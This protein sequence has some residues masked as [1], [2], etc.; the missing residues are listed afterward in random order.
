[1]VVAI[2]I[3]IA[4]V[5]TAFVVLPKKKDRELTAT[6][7]G[8]VLQFDAGMTKNLTVVAMLGKKDITNDTTTTTLFWTVTPSSVGSFSLKAKPEVPFRAAIQAGTGTV[9]CT[10]TYQETPES[11]EISV[12][13][14]KAIS[15]LP[16]YLDA[17]SI[18]P[19]AKTILPDSNW[20]FTATAVSSVGLPISGVDFTWV[21]ATDPGVTCTPNATSGPSIR[22]DAGAVLGNVTL[23]A[24][25]SYAGKTKSGISA[26]KV[27]YL[28]PRSVDYVWY[29]M[30][31]VPIGSWYDA[32]YPIYH[33]EERM[34]DSYPWLF[35]YHSEPDGNLY[36][37]SLMRLNITGRNVSEI[38][39]NTWPEFL[40]IL[41]QSERGGTA[42]IDWYMQYLTRDE[43]DERYSSFA[44]QDDGWIIVLNGT[45]TL[46]KQAAKMVLNLTETGYDTFGSWWSNNQ[47]TVIERYSGFLVDEAESRVD[48][49]NAYESYYQLFT[50]GLDATKEGDKI[51]LRYDLVTWGMEALMLRWLHECFLP[52]EMW[53]EDMRFHMTIMPEWSVIDIDTA[54]TY[55]LYASETMSSMGEADVTP[56]WVFQ[57]LLGDA[58]TSSIA[59]PI[60]A[61]DK[62]AS[63]SYLNRQP[64]STLYNKSMLYD[65]VPTAWNLS[66]NETLTLKWPAGNQ[67]FRY[68]I[69]QGMAVN[70]TE[71][72]AVRY[73]EPM[74]AD[75]DDFLGDVTINNTAR[76]IEFI[77][78]IN[79][80]DWSKTQLNHS[81]LNDEWIRLGVLPYGMPWVEFETM[82]PV[83]ISL[84]HFEVNVADAVPANDDATVTVTAINNYGFTYF[85]YDGN[86]SFTCTDAAA[87]LPANYTFDPIND[88]GVHIFEGVKFQT[89]GKQTLT[90][91]NNTTHVPAE[92]GSKTINVLERRNA[93]SMGVDV[94]YIPA[95]GVPEDV[96]VTVFDQYGDVFLNYTG[97]VTFSS[98]RSAD[99][100]W[101][102]DFAFQ[103]SDAGVNTSLGGLN[104]TVG[105][106]FTIVASDKDNSSVTG[107]ETD[108][109]V[110][111]APEEIDHYNVT[112]IKNMLTRQK[113]DVRVTAYDQYDK[114]FKRYNGTIHFSANA[115]GGVFPADYTFTLDDQG[116]KEF[117]KAVSFTSPGVF[118]VSVNDAVNTSALG[119]QT[120]I[121]IEYRPASQTFRIYDMFQEKWQEYWAWRYPLY[122]TDIILNNESG[123]Y[124][125]IYNP[126]QL[127]SA[128]IIYAPYRWNITG[129]NLSQVSIHEPEFM[130]VLGTPNIQGAEATMDV[131]FQYLTTSSW[132]GYWKPVWNMPDA[133]WNNQLIDGWFPGVMINVTMN[134][135]AA[136]E[137]LGLPQNA[138][139]PMYWWAVNGGKYVQ[140]WRDWIYNEGNVRLDIYAG[141]EWPYVD[142]GTKM[143]MSVKPNGDVFLQIGHIGEGYEI[144]TTRWMNETNLCN[145]EGYFEDMSIRVKFY[146]NWI[147]L[148]FDA[149]CQ[150]SLRAV[151]ANESATNAAWS[152][153]PLLIDY[154][155]SWDTPGG[156]HPSKFD[157]WYDAGK[158]LTYQSWNAGDPKFGKQVKYD[159][160]LSYFN[161][162]D[163]QKFIIELP[164]GDNNIGFNA[165]T[166]PANSI[167]RILRPPSSY[168]KGDGSLWNFTAYGPIMMNG[169]MSLGWYGNW[170][171]GPNLDLMW[172]NY[173][174]TLTMVGPLNFENTHQPNGALYMGAPWIEFNVTPVGTVLSL[175]T[176]AAQPPPAG[177]ATEPAA[178]AITADMIV[179]LSLVA[180]TMVVIATI[181]LIARRKD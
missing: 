45:V 111:P 105:G 43:L 51:V 112:G 158:P 55:A 33:Q 167:T 26:I 166:M 178:N 133:V 150:Y 24:T 21:V 80:Y 152:W 116:Y 171:S 58:W 102:A 100:T 12:V 138:T 19:G 173:T 57:P 120:N 160:G 30:F 42:V 110:A 29:D 90:V 83:K 165:Q 67:T 76:E 126:D 135:A 31:N 156:A 123:K 109:W 37:Y 7:K 132:F 9:K 164:K 14:E 95:V 81:Y 36:T 73:S 169:T 88:Q 66:A 75:N 16:P 174:K 113:S 155:Y 50:F 61:M 99:V 17:V 74:D 52:V 69:G 168:P 137:W 143:K 131:Y 82:D 159:S 162:T 97:T 60:S 181:A 118:T 149:V 175:P 15:V 4:L 18:S 145:H 44:T 127:G 34:S 84:D 1:M 41:S 49:E 92:K 56:C 8:D 59:H 154:M 20:T 108:I 180:A 89:L 136:E 124:T 172:N 64:D 10:V 119:S 13:A 104:F 96:T 101:P 134:R 28:P 125:M 151:K 179:A 6:I 87:T 48:I 65:V 122:R 93:S 115:S 25:G 141:F 161:L 98:N 40:P 170:T 71:E 2:V 77:G 177:F 78:P 157:K 146:S 106:W 103:L 85:G 147:D 153:Q 86:V 38:N 129:T 39:T 3:V 142:A 70:I 68:R 72:I 140:N 117:K 62:Y 63:L 121:V 128:G 176:P 47:Q 22:L 114:L 163:Y 32:R 5:A 91:T 27:G 144:L 54:V 35:L 53:Y 148:D 23:T 79:M 107:N 46:D 11:E 130:P 139:N 94:Y